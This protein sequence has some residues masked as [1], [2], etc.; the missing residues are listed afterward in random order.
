[1]VYLMDPWTTN[2]FNKLALVG[3]CKEILRG[4]PGDGHITCASNSCKELS[5]LPVENSE[6]FPGSAPQNTANV[7]ILL[8]GQLQ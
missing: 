7:V 5:V 8:C 6:E 2:F 1:M 3:S 4:C